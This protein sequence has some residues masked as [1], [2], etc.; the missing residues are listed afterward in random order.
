MEVSF[1][2]SLV[3]RPCSPNRLSI[4]YF[5]RLAVDHLLPLGEVAWRMNLLGGAGCAGGG[6]HLCRR[7][8][9]ARRYIS[10]YLLG[11]RVIAAVIAA[12]LLAVSETFWSQAIIAEVYALHLF[13]AA[14]LRWRIPSLKRRFHGSAPH[15]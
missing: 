10:R 7:P 9:D 5:T 12:A 3:A 15:L 6:F 11:A 4:L 14:I 8:S 1:N 2:L 13:V